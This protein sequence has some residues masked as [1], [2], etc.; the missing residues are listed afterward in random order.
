MD[1]KLTPA[2]QSTGYVPA[3]WAT[4]LAL[5][6]FGLVAAVFWTRE[7]VPNILFQELM[8]W[9]GFF[10]SGKA[11]Y[12]LCLCIGTTTMA[13]GFAARIPMV[14]QPGSLTV[15]I[16]TTL[17]SGLSSVSSLWKGD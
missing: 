10:R 6:L 4:C 15:Y 13:I 11:K 5:A 17:V 7:L 9:K 2:P 16:V 1:Q 3:L 8:K 14:D 12:M